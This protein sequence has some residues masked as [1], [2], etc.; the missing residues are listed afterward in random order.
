M[1]KFNKETKRLS[2]SS[3]A[4][5][6][7]EG[8]DGFL[9][10]VYKSNK[11]LEKG[12]IID[13]VVFGEEFT[14]TILDIAIPKP[15][16][17]SVIEWIFQ[18]NKEINLESVEEACFALDVKSKN[19]Q[20]M[21]DT[22]LEYPEYIEYAKEPRDKFL[23]ANY[24]LGVA[25]GKSILEDAE[26]KLLLTEGIPQ[27]EHTFNYRGFNIFIKADYVQIDDDFKIITVTDLKSSSF[28]G[29]FPDSISKYLYHLQAVI[30]L[31]AIED[32]REKEKSSE[33]SINKF[34]WVVCNSQK[35]ETPLVYPISSQEMEEGRKMLDEAL[36]RLDAL[37]LNDFKEI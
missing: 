6:I 11:Y 4:R 10:P 7:K 2:Y 37:I 19:Y 16:P 17:K 15:Q 30:Y 1:S 13:K 9:N 18:E 32:Y 28:P 27:F 3:I 29:N 36:T 25:I 12:T 21:L 31:M 35:P 22:I 20:K 24:D 23:K 33:Y 34:Y 26:S 5:L 14:E 8:V